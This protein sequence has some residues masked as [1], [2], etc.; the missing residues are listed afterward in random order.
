MAPLAGVKGKIGRCSAYLSAVREHV[1]EHL[2]QSYYCLLHH[3]RIV[4]LCQPMT[5][6]GMPVA[7]GW[8][9]I[10]LCV[11]KDSAL[12]AACACAGGQGHMDYTYRHGQI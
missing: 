11:T 5:I 10:G 6:R 1:P 4:F 8:L 12:R 2:A 9:A 7:M 3:F